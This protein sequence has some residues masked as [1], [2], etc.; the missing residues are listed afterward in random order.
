IP[1]PHRV[2]SPPE[3]YAVSVRFGIA[4]GPAVFRV[5]LRSAP[6]VGVSWRMAYTMETSRTTIACLLVEY[7]SRAVG[8]NETAKT[9]GD[10]RPEPGMYRLSF[11]VGGLPLKMDGK[12]C[13]F[14][15][16]WDSLSHSNIR[17]VE[18]HHHP[19]DGDVY[20]T[21]AGKVQIT[22]KWT[23]RKLLRDLLELHGKGVDPFAALWFPYDWSHYED[24]V[25]HH[26][27]VLYDDK[28]VEEQFFFPSGSP[29]VLE[30]PALYKDPKIHNRQYFD[31]ASE[32]Y[33]YRKFYTE[34]MTGQVMVLR[35]DKPWLYYF[36]R[37]TRDLTPDLT[38]AV[39]TKLYYLLWVVIPVLG[40]IAF[41]SLRF[42]MATA[43][44]I[45]LGLWAL[46]CW[47]LR[48]VAKTLGP[49]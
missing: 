32:C 13:C 29:L 3:Q 37:P 10:S 34:T 21:E 47:R 41:R 25:V 30:R 38:L 12:E 1:L 5:L 24:A 7:S 45:L 22:G 17:D 11:E 4:E 39:L 23:E 6:P 18:E 19:D 33:W 20:V 49:C 2:K 28:F 48:K 26:F 16:A 40:A 8:A 15:A 36:E 9:F 14:G 31:E 35:S 43:A 44:V 42:V 46:V 27:F